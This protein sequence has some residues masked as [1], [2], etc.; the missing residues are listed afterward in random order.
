SVA[1][2]RQGGAL[3]TT[4][5]S[6]DRRRT[7]VAPSPE[8]LRRALQQALA[9][10]EE[11]LVATLGTDDPWEVAEVAA[12]LEALA[13]RLIPNQ[14]TRLRTGPEPRQDGERPM[15]ATDRPTPEPPRAGGEGRSVRP[16]RA[17]EF[18][19]LYEGT[20]GW[21]VGHP[22]PAFVRLA[23]AGLVQGRVLDVG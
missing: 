1:R 17:E 5:D 15:T 4:I 21:D 16:R 20:P 12:A 14:L 10:I 22:Q 9:S 6:R 2:L 3:L 23:E 18:D 7:L 19:A 11:V 8:V 13:Q